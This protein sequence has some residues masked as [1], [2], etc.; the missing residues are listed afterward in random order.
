MMTRTCFFI[1][2]SV[3][4]LRTI[5]TSNRF[6]WHQRLGNST[7][8]RQGCWGHPNLLAERLRGHHT[9]C[10]EATN[11][12]IGLDLARQGE[13]GVRTLVLVLGL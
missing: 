10:V 12:E 9:P 8:R 7:G 3:N 4:G 2:F 1:A 11:L 13:V 5:T 6:G